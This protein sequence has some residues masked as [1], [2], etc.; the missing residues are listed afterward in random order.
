MFKREI[1]LLL[2]IIG[3]MRN[4]FG[5]EHVIVQR[6]AAVKVR[7]PPDRLKATT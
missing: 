5:H 2:P 4:S 1:M 6:V 7:R 3:E